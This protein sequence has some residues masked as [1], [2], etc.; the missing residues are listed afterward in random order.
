MIETTPVDMVMMNHL[1]MIW[2]SQ[3][4]KVGWMGKGNSYEGVK[5]RMI[6]RNPWSAGSQT[7]MDSCF[8]RVSSVPLLVF[9]IDSV[10]CPSEVVVR[11]GRS[12]TW[13]CFC[14]S[15]TVKMGSWVW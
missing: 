13:D 10:G 3:P 1:I 2:Y 15:S 9:P 4:A 12:C 14:V 11:C 5:L 8:L 7:G 6:L